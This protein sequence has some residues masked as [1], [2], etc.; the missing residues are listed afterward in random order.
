MSMLY[1]VDI[2]DGM[3]VNYYYQLSIITLSYQI[4]CD[5]LLIPEYILD[6]HDLM[7]VFYDD[8]ILKIS[9]MILCTM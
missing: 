6:D 5:P 9:I 2:N 1:V 4:C 8:Q 7:S 3:S